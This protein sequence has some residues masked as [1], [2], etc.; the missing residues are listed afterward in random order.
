MQSTALGKGLLICTKEF[1][2][3][4]GGYILDIYSAILSGCGCPRE[5]IIA[6]GSCQGIFISGGFQGI[7]GARNFGVKEFAGK[8][9]T[10]S[11]FSQP[12]I[13]GPRN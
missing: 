1:M 7:F 5:P 12:A 11:K 6:L 4:T 9:I 13:F 3:S 10:V 8:E 2:G